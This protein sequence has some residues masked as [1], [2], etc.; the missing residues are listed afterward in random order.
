MTAKSCAEVEVTIN[1]PYD[2]KLVLTWDKVTVQPTPGASKGVAVMFGECINSIKIVVEAGECGYMDVEFFAK[3]D[4]LRKKLP[5]SH[6]RVWLRQNESDQHSV[7]TCTAR[8]YLLNLSAMAGFPRASLG[9]PQG[10]R[11]SKPKGV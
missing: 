3:A 5:R 2:N 9:K 11:I 10:G 6:K 1:E 7:S 4:E 8:F